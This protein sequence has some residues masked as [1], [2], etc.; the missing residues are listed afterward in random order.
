MLIRSGVEIGPPS[1]A[2]QLLEVS[3]SPLRT[4]TGFLANPHFCS[5]NRHGSKM[6]NTVMRN[7]TGVPVSLMGG[8]STGVYHGGRDHIGSR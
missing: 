7:S 5:E 8:Y 1:Y 2:S 6:K 4:S 3:I